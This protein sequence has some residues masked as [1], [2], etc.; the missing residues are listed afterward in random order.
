M[1]NPHSHEIADRQMKTRCSA[2][3]W[4]IRNSWGWEESNGTGRF[5]GK[6][7]SRMAQ[8]LTSYTATID[9]ASETIKTG[10]KTASVY[11]WT[12]AQAGLGFELTIYNPT[13]ANQKRLAIELQIQALS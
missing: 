1:Y 3:N 4:M 2:V 8:D 10:R 12:D 9:T 7:P 6:C 5:S 13:R 11:R